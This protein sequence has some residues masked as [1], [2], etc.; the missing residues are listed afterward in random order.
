MR[1]SFLIFFYF[2][3]ALGCSSQR[4]AYDPHTIQGISGYVKEVSGNRMPSPDRPLP[5]PKPLKT[6]VY[7]YEATNIKQVDRI[8]TSPFYR[9]IRTKF[10]KSVE[11]NE[12][13]Y[14]ITDLPA[15][16][17]SLFTK[18]D[19]KFYANSFDAS[20]NIALV[21]VEPKKLSEVNIT[22]SAKAVF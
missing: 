9:T 19:G 8:G 14:F 13:G 10:I 5:L 12:Q 2:I 18:V 3:L 21:T 11:S 6:T 22:V 17:Y 15:G 16:N 4:K 20:N 7:I 1:L